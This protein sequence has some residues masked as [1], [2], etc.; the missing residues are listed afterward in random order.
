MNRVII[1]G[2]QSALHALSSPRPACS[3]VVQDILCQ[4]GYAQDASFVMSFVWTP[5]H[6]G[7]AGNATADGF[8]KAACLLDVDDMGAEP[9]LRCQQNT[10]YSAGFAM[11]VQCRN[12]ERA[13]SVS[14]QHHDHFLHSR[15]KYR[16]RGLMVRR[17]NAVSAR[18]RLRYWPL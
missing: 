15:Y 2:S 8:A 18:L 17:H 10:I 6:I 11:T 4:L 13:N 14:I 12:A 16:K 7:L 5:S 3:H 1:C 9:S